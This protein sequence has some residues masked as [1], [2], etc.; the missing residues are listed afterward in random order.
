[1]LKPQS[2]YGMRPRS[3]KL[4]YKRTLG[5]ALIR[6]PLLHGD[7]TV[8]ALTSCIRTWTE[9]HPN[10]DFASDELQLLSKYQSR[11]SSTVTFHLKLIC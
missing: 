1:M 6:I 11:I 10:F 5:D 7:Q 8:F 4:T 9:I 2:E 3:V